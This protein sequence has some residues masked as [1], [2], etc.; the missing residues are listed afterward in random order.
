MI[1][2][3]PVIGESGVELPVAK[4]PYHGVYRSLIMIVRV[5]LPALILYFSARPPDTDSSSHTEDP[6]K[7]NTYRVGGAVR[8]TLLGY[9]H[10]ETDWV[11]ESPG[12]KMITG[13]Y[14]L[15][16]SRAP[17]KLER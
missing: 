13:G 10:H 6:D 9:P 12:R 11:V 16:G 2:S 4:S 1:R 7:L 8:D 5:H 3:Y 14:R 17:C 15:V